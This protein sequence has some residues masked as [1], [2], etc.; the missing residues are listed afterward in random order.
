MEALWK[1]PGLFFCL[2]FYMVQHPLMNLMHNEIAPDGP[3]EIRF[4]FI[5][6]PGGAFY[7]GV[8]VSQWR[9]FKLAFL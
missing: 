4:N 6:I 5:D 8:A 7:Q 1:L 3:V 9:K 2:C